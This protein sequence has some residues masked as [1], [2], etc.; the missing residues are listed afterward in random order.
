MWVASTSGQDF[1]P[2][3]IA[4][5]LLEFFWP[6]FVAGD[7]TRN[8]GMALGLRSWWSLLPPV[9]IIAIAIG[10]ALRWK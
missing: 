6:K 1:P 9:S 4:N 2:I 8:L 5:P 10:G 3:T 7:I